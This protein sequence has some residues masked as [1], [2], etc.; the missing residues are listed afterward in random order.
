MAQF[1]SPNKALQSDVIAPS[2]VTPEDRKARGLL[3]RAASG[4]TG[5]PKTNPS[6]GSSMGTKVSGGARISGGRG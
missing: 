4:H 5:R 6:N 2:P 3:S 1:P